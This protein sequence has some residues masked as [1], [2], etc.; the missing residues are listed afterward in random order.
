MRIEGNA[1]AVFKAH[2][3]K[4]LASIG[5]IHIVN[6]PL[7]RLAQLSLSKQVNRIEAGHSNSIL[8]DS[9][10]KVL[11]A[12]P[13]YQGL[14]LPQAYTGKGVVVGV[15]DIGFD[16]THPNFCDS[17][18]QTL[19]IKALWDQ[20]ST[21]TIGSTLPV[22]RDYTTPNDLLNLRHTRDGKQETHGT[23]TLGIAAGS[24]FKSPYRGM[25]WEKRHLPWYSKQ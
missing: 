21:D 11:N 3:C 25:A 19:R 2:G 22:G 15:Q 20:L 10:A 16:L 18:G 8:T 9:T 12:W 1:E 4:S 6:I 7:N 5:N 23:H 17:T 13:A 14:S 24:G